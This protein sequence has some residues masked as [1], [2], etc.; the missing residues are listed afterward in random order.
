MTKF[1]FDKTVNRNGTDSLKWNVI[2]GELP[3]WV[4]DM[5]FETAPE[6]KNA[7]MRVA[8]RG[9]FGYAT[10]PERWFSAIENWWKTRHNFTIEK[11]WLSFCTGVIPA[12]TS[13]VKRLSKVGDNVAVFTPVYDIFFHSIENTGRRVIECPLAYDGEKYGINFADFEDKI[14]LKDTTLLILCNPH[15]PVGK[16]WDKDILSK[17]GELCYKH[18]VRVISDEI[19]C[20]LTRPKSGYVPFASVSDICR[21][22]SATCVSISKAFNAAGLQSAAVFVPNEDM[23]SVLFRGLNADEVAEPNAFAC[24]SAVAAF[25]FGGQWLD[26]LREYIFNNHKI[27]REFVKNNLPELHVV[28]QDATY[29]AWVDV[30]KLTDDASVLCGHIRKTTGL[31]ITAGNQYRGNGKDFVRINIACPKCTLYD[32]LDRLKK[33]IDSF[34]G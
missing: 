3:M 28:D 14:S 8:E 29:L 26:A 2:E 24:E 25:T 13:M 12:V 30:S 31:F 10:I 9:V 27:L 4:A 7:V 6:V 20:D 15:N 21:D 17:I 32:G 11:K 1:D 34:S 22:I 33:G 23:R 16:I 19:H 5:D 18:N